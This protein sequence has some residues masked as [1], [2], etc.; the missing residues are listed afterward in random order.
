MALLDQDGKIFRLVPA[1]DAAVVLFFIVVITTMLVYLYTPPL[2]HEQEDVFFQIYF[3]SNQY[4]QPFAYAMVQD[5]F[6]PGTELISPQGSHLTITNVTFTYIS[7]PSS[8]V[9]FLLTLNGTLEKGSD[10][11]YLFNGYQI[12]PGKM[13]P[14]QINNSYFIG[15][16]QRINFTHYEDVINITLQLISLLNLTT[17][18][19]GDLIYN[20]FGQEIGSVLSTNYNDPIIMVNLAVDVYDGIVIFHENPLYQSQPFTFKTWNGIYSST[21]IDINKGDSQ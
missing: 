16:V 3:V 20:S 18:S 8:N 12:A 17:L 19:A 13:I 6:V 9:N 4:S 5:I 14:L 1:I 15:T 2:V 7:W 21:I 11:Q 10:G